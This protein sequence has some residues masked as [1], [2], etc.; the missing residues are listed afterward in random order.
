MKL[1]RVIWEKHIESSDEKLLMRIWEN[2]GHNSLHKNLFNSWSWNYGEIWASPSQ[3]LRISLGWYDGN[4]FN[5]RSPDLKIKETEVHG[6]DERECEIWLTCSPVQAQIHIIAFLCLSCCTND[7]DLHVGKM[8]ELD[9]VLIIIQLNGFQISFGNR[10]A[11][12]NEILH[13]SPVYGSVQSRPCP[14]EVGFW[15]LACWSS[16]IGCKWFSGNRNPGTD[17]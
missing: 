15:S 12:S 9:E 5:C 11:F 3:V 13:R 7:L 16:K 17:L 10:N 2:S 4:H 14:F 8:Q 6:V 1:K